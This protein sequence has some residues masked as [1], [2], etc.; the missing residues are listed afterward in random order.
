MHA[1]SKQGEADHPED[2]VREPY[3]IDTTPLYPNTFPS[4]GLWRAT[5]LSDTTEWYVANGCG[6]PLSDTMVNLWTRMRN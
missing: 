2:A 5:G 1:L 3:R 6:E 4:L